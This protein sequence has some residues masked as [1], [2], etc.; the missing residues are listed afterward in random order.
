MVAPGCDNGAGGG[1]VPGRVTPRPYPGPVDGDGVLTPTQTKV[2]TELMGLGAPRPSFDAGLGLALRDEMETVLAGVAD[3]LGDQQLGVTK[4]A[5]SQVHACERHAMSEEAVPFEW[6][7]VTAVGAVSHKAIELSATMRTPPPPEELVDLALDRLAADPDWGPGA[8][9]LGADPVEVAE[10]RGAALDRV[11]KFADEFPP[12]KLSWRPRLESSLSA[13]LC[14]DRIWLRGKVDLALGRPVGTTAH[15]LIVDFKTGRPGRAC[16][17]DLRFYALLET[18]RAGVPPFRV[19]SWYLDSGQYH[20]EDVTEDLLRSAARRT[21]DG[22]RA[23][24]ELRID[25]RE[26]KLAPGPACGY[27]RERRTCDGAVTWATQREALGLDA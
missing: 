11:L 17:D 13:S 18:L 4:R 2:L 1:P 16:A 10:L 5:L 3:A 26:P 25:G 27:C 8:W 14:A 23:L 12:I 15:V 22:A 9:L 19:A 6:S 24:Y 20:A 21:V 7:P